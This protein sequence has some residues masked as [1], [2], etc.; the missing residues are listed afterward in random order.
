MVRVG[1]LKKVQ[2]RFGNRQK[3]YSALKGKLENLKGVDGDGC[4]QPSGFINDGQRWEIHILVHKVLQGGCFR[5]SPFILF[6]ISFVSNHMCGFVLLFG[7]KLPKKNLVYHPF[8][9]VH[10]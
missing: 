1:N 8:F 7:N 6:F 5:R 9:M 4:L 2:P 10:Y 3:N